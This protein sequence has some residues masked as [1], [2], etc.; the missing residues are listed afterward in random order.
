M[1]AGYI[2]AG[3]KNSRMQGKKKLF[4][5][6]NDRSFLESILDALQGIDKVYLSVED[7]TPY[8]HL[9]M[10]MVTDKILGIGPIGGIY[11]GLVSCDEDALLVV[12]CDMPFI[13]K[14]TIKCIIDKYMKNKDNIVL[15]YADGREQPLLGIYPKTVLPFFEDQIQ[16]NNYKLR[17][18]LNKAG[19]LV[20]ELS[21]E[22]KSSVNINTVLEYE[23]LI[24]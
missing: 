23:T 24:N 16:N 13:S 12:A 7:T 18:L 19:Y 3:G 22:D 9:N 21:A 20:V 10:P 15:A 6:Y 4:L 17:E 8:I 5:E 2:V 14:T 1:I 11:S